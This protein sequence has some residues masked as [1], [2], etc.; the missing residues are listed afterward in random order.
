MFN[1]GGVWPAADSIDTLGWLAGSLDDIEILTAVLR[2]QVPQPPRALGAPPRIGV[3]RTDLWDVLQNESRAAVE[4]AALRLGKAGAKV[5]DVEMPAA[6]LGLHII[7][8]STIGFYE[9]AACMAYFWDHT[10]E[11][12]SPQMQRYIENGHKIS[13]EEYVAGLRR[14]DECRA[15]LT[16]LFAD[17]DVLLVPAAIGEAPKGLASTG[18]AS[19]QAIW[20]ALHTPSLTL[21]THRGPNNLPI[22]IQ[23]VGQRYED[24]RLLACARFVWDKI[25]AEELVGVASRH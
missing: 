5:R 3:W 21:P 9:R 7:A 24:D 6:F 4:D 18:D 12:L 15:L 13:R 2:M 1:K 14:L 19:P 16:P 25:G 17:I 23:L 10:R 22:G 20:T 8:R 11:K